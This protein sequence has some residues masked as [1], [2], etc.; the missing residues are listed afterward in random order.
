VNRDRPAALDDI[1]RRIVVE[2]QADGRLTQAEL[3][4]RVSLSAPAVAERVRRLEERGVITGYTAHVDPQALGYALLA[5]VRVQPAGPTEV[6]E[7]RIEE[8]LV[9]RPEVVE[10]HHLTGEDCFLV[11]VVAGD[12]RHL[13]EIVGQLARL[14]RTT[15]SLVLSS[16]IAHRAVTPAGDLDPAQIRLGA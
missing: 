6:Y 15:T 2:L 11:K 4:R 14:G 3:S 7:R 12:T 9:D 5:Y 16:P 10:C 8:V 13:E 1:D